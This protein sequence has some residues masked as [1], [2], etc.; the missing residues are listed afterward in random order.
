MKQLFTLC[1]I[2]L[3]FNINAQVSVGDAD[4]FGEN[5]KK[6]STKDIEKFKK[7]KTLFVLSDQYSKEEY[8][9]ILDEVWKVTDFEIL[10]VKELFDDADKNFKLTNSIA[11]FQNWISTTTFSTPGKAGVRKTDYYFSAINFSFFNEIKRDKKNKLVSKEKRVAAIFFSINYGQM[12]ED[13]I[14]DIRY[15]KPEHLY[16]YHLGY[17]KNYLKNI[18]DNLMLNKNINVYG[19][20]ENKEE[21]SRLRTQKLYIT[22]DV[23]RKTIG[24]DREDRDEDKLTEDYEFKKEIISIEE[25]N[26]KI[27][28]GD[29]F[30]Y[31]VYTQINSKKIL[32]IINSKTGEIVYNYCNRM[33]YNLKGKDF[34]QISKAI[35]K[36]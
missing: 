22:D 16:N 25:L 3:S 34:K 1:I 11:R 13:N 21:L 9:K 8:K 17:L 2:F 30:Y 27:L 33:A 19:D 4:Y 29:E 14:T 28:D 5:T 15:L 12:N 24:L 18:N 10:T 26:K 36:S 7:T 6:N 20:F 35:S 31:F 32:T 23:S